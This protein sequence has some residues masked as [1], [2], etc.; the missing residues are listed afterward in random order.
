MSPANEFEPLSQS[1]GYYHLTPRGW[2]RVDE[3][4]FPPDRVETWYVE[5]T[6]PASDAKERD[7]LTRV[8]ISDDT[9]IERIEEYRSKFG[10]A[11]LPSRDRSLTVNCDV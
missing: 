10:D 5:T 2:F 8:W 6:Q 3:W 9:P 1:H 7:S 11:V 4:P